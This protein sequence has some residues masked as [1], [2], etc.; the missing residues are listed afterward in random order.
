MGSM[1]TRTNAVALSLV[2][3]L[4]GFAV[5]C[6]GTTAGP[7]GGDGGADDGSTG[8]DGPS[9]GGAGDL[10]P[11]DTTK[12][13]ITEKGGFGAPGPDGSTCTQ[14]DLTY[15]ITLPSRSLAWKVCEAT[16]AGPLAFATGQTTLSEADFA[17]I[18]QALHG[19]RR[20]TKT[21]CGADKP[22]EAIVFT[23]PAGETTYLDDFYFCDAKDTKLYVTGI[24]AVLSAVRAHAK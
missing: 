19:L 3:G 21:A 1:R 6:S 12:I 4:I 11:A 18:A 24:D 23:T 8:T 22:E 5:A 10:F 17:P 16:D 7:Y 9:D 2:A 15:T 20:A 14:A 13:V